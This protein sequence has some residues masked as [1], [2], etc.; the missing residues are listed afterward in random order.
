MIEDEYEEQ[1]NVRHVVDE[2]G[3]S[4]RTISRPHMT[5]ESTG[6]VNPWSDR[7]RDKKQVEKGKKEVFEEISVDESFDEEH[8]LPYLRTR[9]SKYAE[10]YVPPYARVEEKSVPQLRRSQRVCY[11]VDRLTYNGYMRT[12]YAYMVSHVQHK[13][14]TCFQEAIGKPEWESAMDDE[15]DAL[16][17]NETWDLVRLPSGKKA[18]GSKWV[19]KVKCKSDGSVERYKARLVAKGMHK[20]KDGQNDNFYITAESKKAVENSPFLERLKKNGYKGLFLMDAIDEYAIGQLKEYDGKKLVSATKKGLKLD[21]SEDE[22]KK[23]EEKKIAVKSL[24]KIIQ[25]IL[26]DRVEKVMVLDCIVDS[27]CCLMIG[28]YGWT[29]NMERIMKIQL[30]RPNTFGSRIYR[31]LKLALR[32]DDDISGSG[33]ANADADMVALEDGADAEGRLMNLGCATGHPSFVICSF[34]NQVITQLELRNERKF[35][36]YAK[37]VY[38]LPK[39]LDEK[40]ATL[41]L[42]KLHTKLTKLSKDQSAYINVLVEISTSQL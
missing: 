3:P 18:I 20:Q 9:G 7:L 23:K 32:I 42:T 13:E 26:G 2:P 34:T 37:Q 22:K 28:E 4:T 12:H 16:V 30:R 1:K 25:D 6:S 38:I 27:P 35:G 36:K 19:Y 11:P 41:H 40:V 24:C 29:A 33:D 10:K 15:M 39:H 14:L 21:E 17:K 5:E 8:G 31:M